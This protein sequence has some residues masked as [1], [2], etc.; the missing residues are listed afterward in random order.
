MGQVKFVEFSLTNLKGYGLHKVLKLLGR[1]TE[2]FYSKI[3]IFHKSKSAFLAYF[4]SFFLFLV[5]A[6]ATAWIIKLSIKSKKK[7]LKFDLKKY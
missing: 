4:N 5:I 1:K 7:V 3:V 6:F 2:E